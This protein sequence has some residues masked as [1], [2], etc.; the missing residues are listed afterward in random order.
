MSKITAATDVM[1][2]PAGENLIDVISKRHKAAF[3]SPVI[4]RGGAAARLSGDQRAFKAIVSSKQVRADRPTKSPGSVFS[5]LYRLLASV[6]N[7]TCPNA[8]AGSRFSYFYSFHTCNYPLIFCIFHLY[9]PFL[10]FLHIVVSMNLISC[11]SKSSL[12]RLFSKVRSFISFHLV[13]FFF[14]RETNIMQTQK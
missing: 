12:Q 1:M 8:S 10:A 7:S 11:V 14:G 9:G 13:A 2:A 3:F 6:T 4:G 5:P